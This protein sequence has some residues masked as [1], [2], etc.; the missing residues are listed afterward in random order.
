MAA[1]EQRITR[2]RSGELETTPTVNAVNGNGGAVRFGVFELDAKAGKLH[3]NGIKVKLQDQPFQVLA[4][5]LERPGEVVSREEL[6]RRLWSADTFVDF[7]HSI[8]AAIKR[9]RDALG[10]SADNPRFVETLPKR[11]YRLL[12]HV[13]VPGME[14]TATDKRRIPLRWIAAVAI[15]MTGVSVGWHAGHRRFRCCES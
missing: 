8:N 5:L 3:R 4:I 11:G 14:V 9:L 10:D 2:V 15:F 13:G 6:Q 12:A 1:N 7:D